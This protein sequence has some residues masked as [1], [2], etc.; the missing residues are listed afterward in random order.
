MS[1]L[2]LESIAPWS[3]DPR[4]APKSAKENDGALVLEANGTR[5]CAGGWQLL[6]SGIEPGRWYDIA[7]EVAFDGLAHPR[8]NLTGYVYW[9]EID[10]VWEKVSEEILELKEAIA[11]ADE[12]KIHEEYGDLLFSLV[13]LSRFIGINPEESHRCAIEKFIGRFQSLETRVLDAGKHLSDMTLNEMDDLW[14]EI[15]ADEQ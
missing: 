4:V 12:E 14:N 3:A 13:N 7:V 6:Y 2:K 8:D 5:T 9:G 1:D 11:Q 10:P 15:K